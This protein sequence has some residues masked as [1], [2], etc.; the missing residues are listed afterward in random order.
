M[1]CAEVIIAGSTWIKSI[2]IHMCDLL[3]CCVEQ[4]CKFSGKVWHSLQTMFIIIIDRL[5]YRL[6][7]LDSTR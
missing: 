7:D 2:L 5:L 3:A 4:S 1:I 6:G